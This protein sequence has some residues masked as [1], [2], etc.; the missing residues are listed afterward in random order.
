MK[1]MQPKSV[2]YLASA[3]IIVL[4]VTAL[5]FIGITERT[6]DER[7]GVVIDFGYWEASWT[8]MSFL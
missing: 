8:D 3:V 2:K 4:I 5:P 6:L 1:E 7:Q